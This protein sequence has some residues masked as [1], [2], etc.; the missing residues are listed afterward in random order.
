M[1]LFLLAGDFL[2]KGGLLLQGVLQGA[3]LLQPVSHD[4]LL[5]PVSQEILSHLLWLKQPPKLKQPLN[6]SSKPQPWLPHRS[7][8]PQP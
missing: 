8:L 7:K 4:G 3:G 2:F 1:L 5:Q 6:L